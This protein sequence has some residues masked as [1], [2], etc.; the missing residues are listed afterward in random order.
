[1]I[2][3][4]LDGVELRFETAPGLFSPAGVDPGTAAML[5]AVRFEPHDKV[6]DLGCGWGLVGVYAATLIGADRIWMVDDDPHAVTLAARNAAR[7][8][9]EGVTV[10]Q[11]DGVQAL[12]ETGFTKILCNPPYHAD[13]AVPKR[14]I[15]KGFNR[16]AIGGSL[17]MVTR[18]DAWY[19][20]KLTA[21]FGGVRVRNDAGYFVF[22]A[23]KKS[24]TYA[25]R[26]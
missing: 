14:F 25:N 9:V 23:V 19:R 16:L 18:R 26:G 3:T 4:T 6:L 1:V 13:F 15:E 7:N 24:A 12:N 21:I 22:E 8:G 17:F 10:V 11:S 2:R 5:A 20:N